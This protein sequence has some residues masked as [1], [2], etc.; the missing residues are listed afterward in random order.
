MYE[1]RDRWVLQ[2]RRGI[3]SELDDGPVPHTNSAKGKSIGLD[4]QEL[5]T[6]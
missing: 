1:N 6:R 3:A 4:S 5:G 2:S